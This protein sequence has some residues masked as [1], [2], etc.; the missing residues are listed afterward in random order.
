MSK[1]LDHA[2]LMAARISSAPAAGE[3]PT[4][5]DITHVPCVVDRQKDI[6]SVIN[7]AVA[8]DSGIAIVILW[9]GFTTLDQDSPNPRIANRYTVTVY[10]QPVIAG[11]NLP[12][13]NVMESVIQRLLGWVPAG[14]HYND[15]AQINNGGM[16][17]DRSLLI[18]DCEVTIPSSL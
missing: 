10:S 18:Y 16:M 5:I 3:E 11:A 6:L 7:E 12:A 15:R 4:T 17:P 13:D 2:D 8:R 14:N 1:A 9:Q